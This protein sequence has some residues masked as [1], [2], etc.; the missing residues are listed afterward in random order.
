MNRLL[1]SDALI[2][3]V[4]GLLSEHDV[5]FVLQL[6]PGLAVEPFSPVVNRLPCADDHDLTSAFS[7]QAFET[8]AR[9]ISG[10]GYGNRPELP[11]EHVKARN[12]LMLDFS[13]DQNFDGH[14]FLLLLS[15]LMGITRTAGSAWQLDQRA[16]QYQ[17]K[18]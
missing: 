5:D 18:T 13:L 14:V 8:F 4:L 3:L 11:E 2:G 6:F 15:W 16:A 12:E 7:V 17:Y 1:A 10:L 9:N